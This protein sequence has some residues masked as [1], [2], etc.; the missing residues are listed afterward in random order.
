MSHPNDKSSP[1]TQT[2]TPSKRSA[3][4]VIRVTVICL[5]GLL[6]I[7]ALGIG[8]PWGCYRYEHLVLGEAVV[9]GVVT[10]I[11]ARLEGRVESVEVDIGQ[12]VAKGDVLLRLE[13]DHLA[14]TVA[15]ER[16]EFA[17]MSTELAVEKMAI[18]QERRRLTLDIARLNG[19][20]K[21]AIGAYEAEK[22]NLERLEKDYGRAAQ[23]IKT[24][25]AAQSEMDQITG[26]RNQSLA[27]VK[28]AKGAV[29][30]AESS[31]QTATTELD[32]LRVREARLAVLE[33][34]VEVARAK[35]KAA[36]AD[37]ASTVIRAPAEG[38][39]LE[40]IVEVG[41]SARVGEP[42]IAMAIGRPWVEAWVDERDLNEI[43]VG[44]LADISLDAFPKHNLSG[45]VQAIGVMTDKH[46]QLAPVPT[47]L[48]TLV[49][50]NAM[51]PVYIALDGDNSNLPL[52]LSAVV[53]IRRDADG[54]EASVGTFLS[55][56][57]SW[58]RSATPARNETATVREIP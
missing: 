7:A 50:K 49:R 47:T 11:G 22:S 46:L 2:P 43:R 48:H 23:L 25:I 58:T 6:T 35:V 16:A 29:D 20:R 34:Q 45:R 14:A 1:P 55:G 19:M 30:A 3:R 8:I 28:S 44:S 53:G 32:G 10:R 17:R 37:L 9:N 27:L 15:E 18:E 52:G 54:D 38:R 33:S 40:R 56:L 57:F 12:R 42:M 36:E 26:Q 5:V 4:S 39:V 13:D 41:G 51:V 31:Y 21:A 24:G